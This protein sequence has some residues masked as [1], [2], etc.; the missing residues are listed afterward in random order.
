MEKIISYKSSEVMPG[1]ASVLAGQ[2]ILSESDLDDRI[3]GILDQE[4]LLYQELAQPMGII[5]TIS[6]DDFA[7]IYKGEGLNEIPSPVADIYPQANYLALFAVTVGESVST[8]I[9]ELFEVNNFAEGSML[10]SV[11][12]ESADLTAELIERNYAQYLL[13]NNSLSLDDAVLRY[14][15]GYC[16][17]HISAQKKLFEY[18]EAD[19]IGISL[20]ES[21]LMDPLKSI[22]GV[23]IAGLKNIHI[24]DQEYPCC[25]KCE[26]Y[27]CQDRIQLLN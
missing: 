6:C 1:T 14:S 25:D 4:V 20:R 18:L 11:A 12:S 19:K 26:T 2:G 3:R 13:Q 10:D 5:K 15:P 17:W 22:S 16:G 21:F 9:T 23:L 24:F 27:S 7:D 8:K